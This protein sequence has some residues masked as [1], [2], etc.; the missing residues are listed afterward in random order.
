MFTNLVYRISM[1]TCAN[2]RQTQMLVE[3]SCMLYTMSTC[4]SWLTWA[5][6]KTMVTT[7][8]NLVQAISWISVGFTN[9]FTDW[10]WQ[11]LGI[12]SVSVC[13]LF[14]I[15]NTD[16]YFVKCNFNRRCEAERHEG[17][18][19]STWQFSLCCV[20]SLRLACSSGQVKFNPLP[21]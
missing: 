4:S 14:L 10:Q 6:Y 20:G 21:G 11:Y 19:Q 12:F 18:T 7:G 9:Q 1:L 2:E 8:N 5:G 3:P 13:F 16:T 17:A 15:P